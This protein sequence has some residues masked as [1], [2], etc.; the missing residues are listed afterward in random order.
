MMKIIDAHVH[1]YE[2]LSGFGPKGEARA[3]G[4]GM[5][6]WATGLRERFLKEGHGDYGFLAEKLIE[7]MDEADICHSVILQGSNYGFQNSYIAEVVRKY[8]DRFTGAGTFD[9]YALNAK[10]IF[11]NLTENLGFKILKFELSERFGLSGYHPDFSYDALSPYISLCEEMGIT[12]VLDLGFINSKAFLPEEVCKISDNHKKLTL[13]VA[14]ALFPLYDGLNEERLRYIKMLKRDNVYFDI[15]NLQAPKGDDEK[16]RY[17]RDVIDIV[18]SDHIAWGTDC[19]GV[20]IN[21]SYK[22]LVSYITESG[23]FTNEE[24]SDIMYK[25]AERIY[26]KGKTL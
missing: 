18:G 25:T 10:D 15:A 21:Y 19:P 3:I 13:V 2:R 5:V 12:L 8:P 26:L 9:P 22:D 16:L 1:I 20:F 23:I 24:L 11:K 17:I 6:E 14:H 4:N 7:L